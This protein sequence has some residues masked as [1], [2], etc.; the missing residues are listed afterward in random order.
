MAV[1]MQTRFVFHK[2]EGGT[3]YLDHISLAT[4]ESGPF[5][6]RAELPTVLTFFKK[7]LPEFPKVGTM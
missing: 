3:H 4:K 1:F 2:K 5:R 6:M 7:I